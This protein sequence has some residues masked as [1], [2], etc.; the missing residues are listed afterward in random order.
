MINRTDAETI[1][2]AHQMRSDAIRNF[3]A[4]LLGSH[5]PVGAPHHS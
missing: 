2:A 5:A 3:F 1:R 4:R